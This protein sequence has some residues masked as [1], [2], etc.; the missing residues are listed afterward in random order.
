MKV[1]VTGGRTALVVA[2]RIVDAAQASRGTIPAAPAAMFAA[3]PDLLR[4]AV[5]LQDVSA[6]PAL[7]PAALELPMPVPLQ[8]FGI[9]VNYA[10]HAGEAAMDLPPTPMVFPKFPTCIAGPNDE[11]L[12]GSGTVDWEA[13]LVVVIGAECFG[14]GAAEAAAVIAGYTIG[15]D[16]SDRAVQFEGGANPQFGLGKSA[17]GFGPVGPWIVSADEF[18]REP[19]LGIRCE[20]GGVE[21]QS[22]NTKHLIF[23]VPHIVS[24]LSQRVRLRPGD[25]IFTG[26]PAGVGWG[27]TPKEYLAPGD[28]IVTTIDGIGALTTRIGRLRTIPPFTQLFIQLFAPGRQRCRVTPSWTAPRR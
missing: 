20:V 17:P 18:D 27:R 10:D 1:A 4:L 11:V 24:Y 26:T 2:D 23:D 3:W 28:Q 5:G 8:A 9:G 22:S 19:Q 12:I 21:K 25:I 6:Y 14:A 13:E 15:Q 7:D 16:L